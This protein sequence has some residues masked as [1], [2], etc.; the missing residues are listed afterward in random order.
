MHLE[1][2]ETISAVQKGLLSNSSVE[3]QEIQG[4]FKAQEVR[5]RLYDDKIEQYAI[6]AALYFNKQVSEELTRVKTSSPKH[7]SNCKVV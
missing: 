1:I 2:V 6:K 4:L 3:V 5:K 7:R